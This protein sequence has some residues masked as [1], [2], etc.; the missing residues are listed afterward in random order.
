MVLNLF[1]NFDWVARR[2]NP[3]QLTFTH[4]LY[5]QIPEPA[6]LRIG[7]QLTHINDFLHT[8]VRLI[9]FL[10]LWITLDVKL[11]HICHV[12]RDVGLGDFETITLVFDN[13][14]LV[15]ESTQFYCSVTR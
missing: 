14:L 3:S 7:R 9:I 13:E 6:T 4:Y 11:A 1:L 15:A 5:D 10:E 12:R 8:L 2:G